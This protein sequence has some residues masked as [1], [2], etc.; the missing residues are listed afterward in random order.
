MLPGG[1]KR[2][3]SEKWRYPNT[4]CV[5]SGK[6]QGN[7]HL[8]F[9]YFLSGKGGGFSHTYPCMLPNLGNTHLSF[10]N[11]IWMV[12]E[13]F[14]L[15]SCMNAMSAWSRV[16]VSCVHCAYLSPSIHSTAYWLVWR[17]RNCRKVMVKNREKIPNAEAAAVLSWEGGVDSIHTY[18]CTL[19]NLPGTHERGGGTT[20]DIYMCVVVSQNTCSSCNTHFV[21][22]DI[23]LGRARPMQ[24][25]S[26]WGFPGSRSFCKTLLPNWLQI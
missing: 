3:L 15:V 5:I 20:A 16:T 25:R 4:D 26:R 23:L 10:S 12:S 7:R 2:I 17:T 13:R 6:P 9:S 19:S 22:I 14:P 21:I 18:A 8:S 1:D 11:P 24:W